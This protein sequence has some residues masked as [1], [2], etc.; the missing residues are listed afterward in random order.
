MACLV[1]IFIAFLDVGA[2]VENARRGLLVFGLNVLPVLF[3]FFFISGLLIELSTRFNRPVYF[4]LSYLAGFPTSARML[5][6]A[7][8]KGQIDRASAM[9]LATYT[10]TTSP[11]FIIATLGTAMYGD[12]QLGIII[13]VAHVLGAFATGVLWC[14]S[15][16][17]LVSAELAPPTKTPN[18]SAQTV[19]APANFFERHH[20][21][22]APKID[23][24]D[25]VSRSLNGAI[26]SVLMVGGLIVVFFIATAGMPFWLLGVFEL[27]TGVYHAQA[28]IAGIARAI[29]P[30]AI[31][32]FGGLCVAM[33]GFVF[34]KN[35]QMP[36]WY[37]FGYKGIQTIL[38]VLFCMM[39]FFLT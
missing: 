10:S 29:V 21:T 9:R 25:A 8:S 12:T 3:P 23:V 27:T 15:K 33:Q 31:V 39:I 2:F 34:L 14:P 7:H 22:P 37:Y 38:S 11:I 13:F 35:F 20:K 36:A 24:C 26:Q 18:L 17:I 16:K 19:L 4:A 28:H 32:S 30:C 1:F 5:S 6:I